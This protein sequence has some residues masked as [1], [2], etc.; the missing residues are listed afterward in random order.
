MVHAAM[1][2]ANVR[3]GQQIEESDGELSRTMAVSLRYARTGGVLAGLTGGGAL[4]TALLLDQHSLSTLPVA[5]ATIMG[6]AGT[7]VAA[8]RAGQT[9]QIGRG[10]YRKSEEAQARERRKAE[11]RTH[12]LA[13]QLAA[14]EA[15]VST[16]RT[17]VQLLRAASTRQREE[18]QRRARLLD[19]AVQATSELMMIT[20]ADPAQPRV[21]F[22]NEA[23]ERMTGFSPRDILGRVP[24]A[25]A[26]AAD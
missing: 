26:R 25:S 21:V 18:T 12:T 19:A 11:A 13:A 22:V 17:D 2:D 1:A 4:L 3:S 23:F 10:L 20:E 8:I 15:E 9:L 24:A 16:L 6:A 7:T 14:R 5:L